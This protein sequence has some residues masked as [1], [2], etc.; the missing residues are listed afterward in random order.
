MTCPVSIPAFS[1][2]KNRIVSAISSGFISFPIGIKGIT[3]FSNS[4]SIHPVCVGPGATLFTVIPYFATSR[5]ML[6]VSASSVA[7][8][9]PYVIWPAKI[10][11][12]SVERLMTLPKSP[13]WLTSSQIIKTLPRT[14]TAKVS[15]I[16]FWVIFSMVSSPFSSSTAAL[17]TR[18]STLPN[19]STAAV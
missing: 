12:A 6:R 1:L 15:S 18:M 11:A 7:L 4:S 8:L 3:T 13:R 19:L 10:C 17:L 16:T 5:A 14:L 9:A 2:A